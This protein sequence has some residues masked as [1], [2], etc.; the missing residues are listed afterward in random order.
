MS[1]YADLNQ[2]QL[3]AE[4]DKMTPHGQGIVR[5]LA[6]Q[7]AEIAAL[8]IIQKRL[9]PKAVVHRRAYGVVV[10]DVHFTFMGYPV[11]VEIKSLNMPQGDVLLRQDQYRNLSDIDA[12]PVQPN[13]AYGFLLHPNGIST[14][15]SVDLIDWFLKNSR[16]RLLSVPE[17]AWRLQR[18][19]VR[20]YLQKSMIESHERYRKKRNIP[21]GR[22]RGWGAYRWWRIRACNFFSGWEGEEY[23][24]GESDVSAL[25]L[26]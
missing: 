3:F 22:R 8:R 7:A 13:V 6:G 20:E 15:P 19:A 1:R 10:P 24:W 5:V 9:D 21:E 16:L 2:H 26:G 4:E 12:D 17:I 25:Q 23:Q 11:L 18:S 14:V